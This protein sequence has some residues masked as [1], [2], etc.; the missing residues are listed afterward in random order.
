M[1]IIGDGKERRNIENLCEI[2]NFSKH[3]KFHGFKKNVE[4]IK[5]L[6]TADLLILPSRYYGLGA[7]VNEALMNGVPVVCSNACG[8]ADLLDNSFRGEVF[9]AE[10]IFDL[11]RI[12]ARRIK[13][14]R[15]RPE[16][17]TRIKN[18]LK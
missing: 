16:L 14:G 5:F 1:N 8:A 11:R 12:L 17:S 9:K 3:V 4:A 18:G 2:L 6:K 7:V 10:S 15:K 13:Q